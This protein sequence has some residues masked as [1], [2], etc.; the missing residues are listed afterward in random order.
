MSDSTNARGFSVRQTERK[1]HNYLKQKKAEREQKVKRE[2]ALNEKRKQWS[3]RQQE[4]EQ[5]GRTGTSGQ[6][7]SVRR[8]ERQENQN[9][10]SN[11]DPE[12][13]R[14]RRARMVMEK[15]MSGQPEERRPYAAAQEEAEER[16]EESAG[17]KGQQRRDG[18]WKAGKWVQRERTEFQPRGSGNPQHPGPSVRRSQEEWKKIEEEKLKKVQAKQKFRK[19]YAKKTTKGQPVMKHRINHLLSKIKTSLGK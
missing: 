3:L 4:K 17:N 11:N 18:F 15:I 6:S 1:T 10:S 13:E 2:Q 8:N 12:E 9:S 16:E 7:G 5:A 19:L 14:Q